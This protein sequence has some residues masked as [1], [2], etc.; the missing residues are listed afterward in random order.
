MWGGWVAITCVGISL[1][2]CA[3]FRLRFGLILGRICDFWSWSA[4][5][6]NVLFRCVRQ[7]W[8]RKAKM[9]LIDIVSITMSLC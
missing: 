9:E 4:V 8:R 3:S 5:A 1:V 2:L 6:P 7:I